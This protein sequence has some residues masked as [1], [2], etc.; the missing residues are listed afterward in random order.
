VIGW[1]RELEDKLVVD[2]DRWQDGFLPKL[3]DG[4]TIRTRKVVLAV[5]ITHFEYVPRICRSYLRNCFPTVPVIMTS[6]NSRIA[7]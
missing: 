1:C 6:R 2:V 4:E 3:E 7:A 5:G